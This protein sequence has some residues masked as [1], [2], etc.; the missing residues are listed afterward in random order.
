[1]VLK[2]ADIDS[3]YQKLSALDVGL[4]FEGERVRLNRLEA[5][6]AEDQRLSARGWLGYDRSYEL[7]IDSDRIGLKRIDLLQRHF[8]RPKASQRLN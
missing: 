7:E 8:P 3:G 6:V 2:G 5:A 1:M 4:V